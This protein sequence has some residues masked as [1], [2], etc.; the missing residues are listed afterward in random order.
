MEPFNTFLNQQGNGLPD[1]R[2]HK[3]VSTVVRLLGRYGY[4]FFLP[5]L[6]VLTAGCGQAVTT[7]SGEPASRTGT[8]EL[9]TS[10]P[11]AAPSPVNTRVLPL[12]RYTPVS[13]RPISPTI[14]PIPDETIGLVVQ[15][16]D[17]DTVGVVLEGDPP[18]R[19]Y[20]VHYLGIDSPPNRPDEPWGVVAY[21]TNHKLTNLKVVRL[22]R[23]QTDF[24]NEGQLLRHVY[25][26][27]KL[28]SV[29]LAEQGLARADSVE[30]NT[31]FE[32][33]IRA[34]EARARTGQ[35]G[36]WGQAPTAT[37][38][39]SE[40]TSTGEVVTSTVTL[41]PEAGD[42]RPSEAAT[43]E[44]EATPASEATA[45]NNVTPGATATDEESS[46]Q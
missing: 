21:E 7:G 41:S 27:K 20:T 35:L 42:D 8:I 24:E 43:S 3:I 22:V 15:V 12:E 45:G 4:F 31:R 5:A 36:L 1:R 2:P 13:T 29:V 33:E 17:G 6:L 39:R 23:D 40:P 30:P 34:A 10:L 32:E 9:P 11:S 16:I 19:V 46:V 26:D 18:S 28:M 38:G 37:P 14:T 44:S 25:L